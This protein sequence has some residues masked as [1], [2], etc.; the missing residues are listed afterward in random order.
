MS[1]QSYKEELEKAEA[2]IEKYIH[3][4]DMLN[5]CNGDENN[6]TAKQLKIV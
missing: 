2:G 6:E 4:M 5:K 1:R 3:I